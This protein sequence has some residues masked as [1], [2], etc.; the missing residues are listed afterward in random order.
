VTLPATFSVSGSVTGAVGAASGTVDIREGN[1]TLTTATLNGS[2]N[3]TSGAITVGVGVH[4]IHAH[5][6][7]ED[8]DYNPADSGSTNVT[9]N[10]PTP[11]IAVPGTASVNYG[12]AYSV[13]G[14]VTAS[15][16]QPTGSVTVT[17]GA[18]QIG[19]AAIGPTGAFS[20]PMTLAQLA[21]GP[22]NL[23]IAYAGD[24][25]FPA[26]TSKPQALTVNKAPVT[27]GATTPTNAFPGQKVPVAVTVVPNGTL[28]PGVAALT[29]SVTAPNSDGPKTLA[30]G[31]A[32][33]TLNPLTGNASVAFTYS[34]D[35]NYAAGGI[36]KPIT[37]SKYQLELAIADAG[38]CKS[39]GPSCANVPPG[40]PMPLKAMLTL[41]AGQPT[42][43]AGF[44]PTGTVHFTD[45]RGIGFWTPQD[46]G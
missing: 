32:T 15:N 18:T 42:P 29:G 10:Q 33:V 13:T 43:P 22:H 20:L 28:L 35:A 44:A 7:G 41:A 37:F 34:G 38:N 26:A 31:A 45:S 25:T 14:T 12:I 9:V 30:T 1:T 11:T 23:S 17:Q 5:Y 3:Y 24:A 16:G 36:T 40:V 4:P 46:P 8:A 21:V 19:T 2:G 27:V 39:P 6:N